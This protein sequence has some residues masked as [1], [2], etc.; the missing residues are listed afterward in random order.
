MNFSV[1]FMDR[2]T[3]VIKEALLFKKFKAMPLV[4][5]IFVGI[6]MLPI[7][8]LSA[9][10]AIFLYIFGYLFSIIS[11]PIDR[12]YKILHDEGQSVQHATQFIIYF[13]SW[14]F[15]FSA[16]AMLSF[17]LIVLT[18]M[19]SLFS[20][21][22]YIWTL[23]GFKFHLFASEEDIAVEVEGK[24]NT[25]IPVIYVSVAAAL[26]LILPLLQALSTVA[27]Y[28][29]ITAD[30]FFQIYEMRI[31]AGRGLRMLFA[32]VYSLAV[33]APNPKKETQE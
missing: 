21:L 11:L 30:F 1:N 14:T 26:L 3:A 10:L 32:A 33:F 25:L 24:Y 7:I 23:G 13:L 31:T 17:L 18:V 16:Y 6:F 29:R 22:C 28:P 4:L 15:I 9:I 2:A 8:L 12:L 20:I 19:Y 27:D 5:A